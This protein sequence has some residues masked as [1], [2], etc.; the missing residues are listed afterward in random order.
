MK[1][2]GKMGVK[3]NNDIFETVKAFNEVTRDYAIKSVAN[4]AN[5]KELRESLEKAENDGAP[6]EDIKKAR[7]AIESAETA[8]KEVTRLYNE[9]LFGGI[10]ENKNKF[11]GLLSFITEDLY[12]AYVAMVKDGKTGGW[13]NAFRAFTK[14]LFDLDKVSDKVFNA[15]N[16]DL[17]ATMSSRRYNSTKNLADGCAYITTVNRR[18]FMKMFA[19]ALWDCITNNKTLK[20]KKEKTENK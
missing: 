11:T 14:K 3:L 16:S 19:G 7:N 17:R 6:A 18:T 9:T 10:D 13:N 8:W 1:D 4:S 12:K 5:M 15:I 20:V 2:Y